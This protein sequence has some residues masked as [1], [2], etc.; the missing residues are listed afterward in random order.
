MAKMCVNDM[1]VI[2]SGIDGQLDYFL[3]EINKIHPR[4][5][6][7]MINELNNSIKKKWW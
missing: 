3:E 6:F 4:I 5:K 2:W 7:T 1:L